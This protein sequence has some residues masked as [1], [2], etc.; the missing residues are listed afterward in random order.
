M[1]KKPILVIFIFVLFAVSWVQ[2]NFDVRSANLKGFEILMVKRERA[3]RALESMVLT[4]VKTGRADIV[5][6]HLVDAMSVGWIDFYMVTSHGEVVLFNSV[7]P[8]SSDSYET[9]VQLH[10]P[11]TFWEFQ[12]SKEPEGSVRGPASSSKAAEEEFKF[13]ESD[14][15][16]GRRLKIG[17]NMNR[18]AF[19]D[20]MNDY[21]ST[22]DRR[23]FVLTLIVAFGVFLFSARDLLRVVKTVRTKGVRGLRELKVLSKEAAMLQTGI[24]GFGEVVDRLETANKTLSNQVLPSLRSELYSGRQPP[25]E[26]ECTMVRTDIN[27]FTKIFHSF[28]KEEFLEVINEFFT[29]GSHLISRY[30][31]YIHEFVGDEIIFYF[32]DEEHENSFAA[33]LACCRELDQVAEQMHERTT[34]K[35]GYAFRVKSSVSHG[36]IRFG[37]LL[38]GFSLAGSPLIETTRILSAVTEKN[39]NTIHFDSSNLPRLDQTVDYVESFRTTLRGIDGERTILRYSGHRNLSEILNQTSPGDTGLH[40]EIYAYRSDEDL[41]QLLKQIEQNANHALSEV[42]LELLSRIEVTKCDLVL[43]EKLLGTVESLIDQTV[44]LGAAASQG[45]CRALAQLTIL[46]PRLIPRQHFADKVKGRVSDLIKRLT[47]HPDH[48]V[49]ANTIE[50][51]QSFRNLGLMVYGLDDRLVNST[52]SRVA[53]NSLIYL[54]TDEISKTVLKNLSKRLDSKDEKSAAAALFAWG[55]IAKFHLKHDPVYYRT[56]SDFLGLKNRLEKVIDRHPSLASAASEA[57]LKAGDEELSRR[58]FAQA[59]ATSA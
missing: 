3:V 28:P 59:C 43:T 33:A 47:V 2:F 30:R 35:P 15:G 32:K 7:R 55:E 23:I 34:H 10:P 46:L 13:F 45:A 38:N 14:L 29:E 58:L 24:A 19:L 49:V 16:E 25:Y 52:N 18:E 20:E 31:G 37:P 40:S 21:R 11:D 26:F 42:G 6:G 8:L 36:R 17:Y 44:A 4:L 9:L 50:A 27:N 12:S 51:L 39:E 57:A 48:R 56:Q 53:T 41:V 1:K 5:E 54:G 22:E